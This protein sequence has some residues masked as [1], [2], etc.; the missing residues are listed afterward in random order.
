MNL[1]KD[2]NEKRNSMINRRVN[3]LQLTHSTQRGHKIHKQYQDNG[4]ADLN[5]YNLHFMEGKLI[6]SPTTTSP[7]LQRN[8]LNSIHFMSK[9]V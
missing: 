8:F 5:L 1:I 2:F 6:G 7:L 9:S 4:L 3:L